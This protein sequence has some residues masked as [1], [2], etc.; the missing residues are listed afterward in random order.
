MYFDCIALLDRENDQALHG[1]LACGAD[2]QALFAPRS[3]R[4]GEHLS[5]NLFGR[6]VS[7]RRRLQGQLDD[8][9]ESVVQLDQLSIMANNSNHLPEVPRN[10]IRVVS[11]AKC[12]PPRITRLV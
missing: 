5:D 1:H 9:Y 8:G 3:I 10:W 4:I 7:V 12:Q 11:L 6:H 2:L